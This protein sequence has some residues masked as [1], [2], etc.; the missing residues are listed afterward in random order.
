MNQR[1]KMDFFLDSPLGRAILLELLGIHPYAMADAIGF[2][3][4]RIQKSRHTNEQL[5]RSEKVR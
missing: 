2:D 4:I 3:L 5:V 1:E